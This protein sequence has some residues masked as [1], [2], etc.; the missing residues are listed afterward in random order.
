MPDE[1]EWGLI[2]WCLQSN[3]DAGL[4]VAARMISA[5]RGAYRLD[6]DEDDIHQREV[7]AWT[8]RRWLIE[9]GT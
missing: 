1:I 9:R 3:R 2:D 6:R 7:S 5:H 4:R 8:I